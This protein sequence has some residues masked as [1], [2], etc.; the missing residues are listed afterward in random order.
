MSNKSK[1]IKDK[2]P[3]RS[4]VEPN[5]DIPRFEDNPAMKDPRFRDA[6]TKPQFRPAR[7]DESDDDC[8]TGDAQ[9]A[10]QDERFSAMFT[11]S[12][13]QA[14]TAITD[15]HGRKKKL[16]KEK[17]IPESDAI[18]KDVDERFKPDKLDVKNWEDKHKSPEED[19][20][21]AGD[22]DRQMS[23]EERIAYLTALSRGEV[24]GSSSED[25][26]TVGSSESDSQDSS[27]ESSDDE[28]GEDKVGIL[29]PSVRQREIESIPR[30]QESSRFLAVCNVDWNNV[31]ATDLFVLLNSFSRGGV[32]SIKVY[33]SDFGKEQLSKEIAQGPAQIFKRKKKLKNRDENE[34]E[35]SDDEFEKTSQD[36]SQNDSQD[37]S[38]I[39]YSGDESTDLARYQH[40][41]AESEVL[42][43][44][45]E[46]D[47]VDK[48]KLR[49]YEVSKL[50]YY[51]AV[52]E[53]A[54]TDAADIVYRE[55]DNHEFEHSSAALD[56]RVIPEDDL[57]SVI[58]NRTVRDEAHEAPTGYVPPEFVVDALQQTNIHCTWDLTDRDR[59]R[60]LT[61][62]G[63]GKDAWKAMVEGDDLAAYVASDASSSEE[64]EAERTRKKKAADMRTLL[65]LDDGSAQGEETKHASDSES[66][67]EDAEMEQVQEAHEDG[68][69][70]VTV[71]M[72][73]GELDLATKI[74]SKLN[75]KNE[76][77]DESKTSWD[78]Y[79]EKRKEK[80]KERRKAL[81]K[82]RK[83]V[84]S[85]DESDNSMYGEDPEF[86][87]PESDDEDNPEMDDFFN[88]A[89][90][91]KPNKAT[92]IENGGSVRKASTKAE[93]KRLIAEDEG[94]L[95]A[96]LFTTLL[97]V[98]LIF[99]V[100]NAIRRGRKARLRHAWTCPS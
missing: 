87:L 20:E 97:S 37:D 12:R 91:A 34:D 8:V 33:L 56:L 57:S 85:E 43:E 26:S 51:F 63:V 46:G 15:I 69:K 4:K 44:G 94:K 58:Q 28:F 35:I 53:F 95:N 78:K 1:S 23:P 52:A 31:K 77:P 13:F 79:K 18:P 99:A 27:D 76:M 32:K 38:Q 42:P 55:L 60:K 30:I 62:Y 45:M 86:G 72:G 7:D 50:K 14:P 70:E 6:L 100:L 67:H 16:K 36:G 66:S 64:D 80:R 81:R 9:T 92:R 49:A 96:N 93:L 98:K 88:E 5:N 25:S 65:G 40:F 48:E 89:V 2:K 39:E 47:D 59:E 21:S 82:H 3:N 68:N 11:D 90:P 19:N 84:L 83:E 73:T 29:D 22:E 17:K 74:R 24:D 75:A 61:Q 10:K 41:P 71:S 54:S